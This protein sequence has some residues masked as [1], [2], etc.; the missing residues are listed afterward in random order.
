[1]YRKSWPFILA[2]A[3]ACWNWKC[4][5]MSAAVRSLVYLSAMARSGSHGRL[6]IV[7]VEMAYVTLTAGIYAGMQQRALAL[8]SRQLGNSVI[9]VGVPALAQ[10]FDWLTHRAVGPAAPPKALFAVC[11]LTLISSLFHLHIMR[12]GVFL[13]G[14]AGRTLADDFRRMPQLILGFI[15]WPK[16]LFSNLNGRL[17]RSAE[18]GAAL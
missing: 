12:R 15:L 3:C 11:A 10:F 5:L 9:A 8:R 18:S 17:A 14:H 1:M 6:A 16:T 4:A 7:A 13:T 2:R